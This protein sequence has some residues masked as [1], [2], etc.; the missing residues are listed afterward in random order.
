LLL[1]SATPVSAASPTHEPQAAPVQE[2]AAGEV[3]DFAV[4]LEAVENS[5]RITTFDRHDGAFRQNLNGRI[6]LSVTNVET[7]ESVVRNSSGPGRISINDAGRVV[8]RFGGSSVLSFFEGDVTGRALLYL[9]GGGAEFEI[10]DDGFFYVRAD[11]P[12]HVEDLCATL[13]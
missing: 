2:F 12:A 11:F 3:C 8:I 5:A 4:R 13:A 9:T 1:G 10:G 7:G 6:V